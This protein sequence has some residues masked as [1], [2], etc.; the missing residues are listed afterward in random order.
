MK[1]FKIAAL[2][3][4]LFLVNCKEVEKKVEESQLTINDFVKEVNF[5]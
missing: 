3:G 2:I 1:I 5:K 4:I